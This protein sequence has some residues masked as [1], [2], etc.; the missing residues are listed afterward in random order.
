ME[1]R[2]YFKDNPYPGGHAVKKFSWSAKMDPEAGLFFHFHLETDDYY[3]EDESE[4]EED[5]TVADWQSKSVWGNYHSCT[6]SSTAH[7]NTGIRVAAPGEKFDFGG[8]ETLQLA[9]DTFP[10]PDD[11]EYDDLNF[12]IY[13]LG[14]DSVADHHIRIERQTGNTFHLHWTGKIALTYGGDDEFKYSF[15]ARLGNI[16]FDGIY[17]PKDYTQD[18]AMALLGTLV[19]KPG[20]FEFQDLNPKSFKRE[21]K[22]VLKQHDL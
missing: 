2:I 15:E 22:L 18:Q 16:T 9:A 4:E 8:W 10:L 7:G 20:Q 19:E 21:Y 5:D 1:N 11:W 6:L 17:Y 14:H 12:S 13:L 3:A